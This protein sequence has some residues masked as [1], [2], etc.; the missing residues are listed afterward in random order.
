LQSFKTQ[1]VPL[2]ALG[3]DLNSV[4]PTV[5][6]STVTQT[7]PVDPNVVADQPYNAWVVTYPQSPVVSLGRGPLPG[8]LKC[9]FV[10]IQDVGTG[11]W[12]EFFQS[13]HS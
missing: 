1:D 5:E 11:E 6:F 4:T 2:N 12:T 10:G 8:S 3:S 13:C 9:Q 7:H